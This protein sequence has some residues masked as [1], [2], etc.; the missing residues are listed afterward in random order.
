VVRSWRGEECEGKGSKAGVVDGFD[1][2]VEGG[3]GRE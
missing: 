2:V 3:K 1:C